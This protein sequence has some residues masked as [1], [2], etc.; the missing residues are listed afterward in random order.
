M[1][2]TPYTYTQDCR[3]MSCES[4]FSQAAILRF[5]CPINELSVDDGAYFICFCGAAVEVKN[6]YIIEIWKQRARPIVQSKVQTRVSA[7]LLKQD[8]Q[9]SKQ[10]YP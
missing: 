10:F 1:N 2:E 9:R 8:L 5:L 6:P 4:I 3:C 7:I